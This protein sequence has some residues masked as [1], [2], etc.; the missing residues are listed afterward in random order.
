MTIFSIVK[1]QINR[2]IVVVS[3]K[4]DVFHLEYWDDRIKVKC[5]FREAVR[6]IDVVR[7]DR[8]NKTGIVKVSQYYRCVAG[9]PFAI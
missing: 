9:F 4:I 2:T 5:W 7:L 8:W 6:K 3:R 1:I